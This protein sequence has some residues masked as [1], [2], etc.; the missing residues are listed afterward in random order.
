MWA[1]ASH[2]T[3]KSCTHAH[4]STLPNVARTLTVFRRSFRR[5]N[6]ERL[7]ELVRKKRELEATVDKCQLELARS[8]DEASQQLRA[9]IEGRI[10]D[11]S[12]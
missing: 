2:S 6:V 8:F 12:A 11:L 3:T 4:L 5:P 7:M 10:E 9:S 1:T